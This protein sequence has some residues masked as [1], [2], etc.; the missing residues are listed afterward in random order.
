MST[1]RIQVTKQF[2][3][4]AVK[5]FTTFDY[6]IRDYNQ[7]RDTYE[8]EIIAASPELIH[9]L[10]QATGQRIVP[11]KYSNVAVVGC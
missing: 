8:I 6:K 2:I 3:D 11:R 1:N 9:T 10:E 5:F 4:D 7:S